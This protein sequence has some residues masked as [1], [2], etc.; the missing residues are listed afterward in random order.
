M[1]QDEFTAKLNP[2]EREQL[3][4]ICT[5]PKYMPTP[6]DA[7][8][9][10]KAVS[11]AAEVWGEDQTLEAVHY[12]ITAPGGLRPTDLQKLV[13]EEWQ[14]E[15]F[16]EF[17]NALGFP[18]IGAHQ[19]M[20]GMEAYILQPALRNQ[21]SLL[22]SAESRKS[23]SSDIAFHLLELPAGDPLRT[24]QTMHL[25]LDSERGYEAAK[26]MSEAQ[27]EALRAAI[28]TV[29]Q[30]LK[31]GPA[32]VKQAVWDMTSVEDC[33]RKKLF[34][35][36]INDVIG[37][38]GNPEPLQQII[39]TLHE[40]IEQVASENG[41]DPVYQQILGIAK[42]RQVQN[43]RLRRQEQEAQS[44][45]SG[46][47]NT[48]MGVFGKR[49]I[50]EISYQELELLWLSLRIC[51]EMAQ[52]KAV[53]L[54]F[55]ALAKMEG[56][57]VA[58]ETDEARREQLQ[59]RLLN[60]HIELSKLYFS[61]PE[62]LKKEFKNYSDQAIT[63]LQAYLEDT[64]PAEEAQMPIDEAAFGAFFQRA[65]L[66]QALGEINLLNSKLEE[67]KNALVDI[68]IQQERLLGQ[69]IKRD[70]TEAD[71]M[72][73]EQLMTRLTLSVTN[74]QLASVYRQDKKQQSELKL[75][76]ETNLR[77]AEQCI[78]SYP[79][80]GRVIH[81][82]INAT[83]EVGDF[84]QNTNSLV[85]AKEAYTKAIQQLQRLQNMRVDETLCRDVAML[86]TKLGQLQMNDRFRELQE[87]KKNL[88]TAVLLW[89]QLYQNTHR[90][91]F[92]ANTEA[93]TKLLQQIK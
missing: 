81:F 47:L 56:A 8:L 92:K 93:I 14:S 48:V 82:L 46:A 68:Q 12:I 2:Q 79:N 83:L 49:P 58:A 31:D 55:D 34:L 26:Y 41:T 23:F 35:L 51:Q 10:M 1:K 22:M 76:L 69:L 3:K 25:L 11:A 19:I 18:L 15:P 50:E 65:A 53:A 28:V 67:A 33:D 72:S 86:H 60:Q 21:L 57:K 64:K 20:P 91:E 9:Y 77:L 16:C 37:V 44:L 27:G 36:L 80:D 89:N 78:A 5:E 43:A 39:N 29:G 70:G 75:V 30:A 84:Y 74:H 24:A 87:A 7:R 4:K 38:V 63:L 13:G 54:L 52:I 45:F 88:N 32:E 40:R 17:V 61:L 66:A 90:P 85:P 59:Q 6:D 42:L 71:K 62:E 73:Q